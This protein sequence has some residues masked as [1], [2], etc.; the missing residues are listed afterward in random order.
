M[1]K[2]THRC[3]Y[4]F[5]YVSFFRF[6]ILALITKATLTYFTNA[7]TI[8]LWIHVHELKAASKWLPF[9]AL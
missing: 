2:G 4:S 3:I 6:P 5:H 1:D 7:L 8:S 9:S